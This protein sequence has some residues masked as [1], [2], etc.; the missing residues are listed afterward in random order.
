M[1]ED[2]FDIAGKVVALLSKGDPALADLLC[3]NVVYQNLGLELN[4][5]TQV[6]A[7]LLGK[8]SGRLYRDAAWGAPTAHGNAA[9]LA[10]QLPPESGFNDKLLLLH[11]R[12]DRVSAIQEQLRL[13]MAPL[14]ETPLSIGADLRRMI[15]SALETRSPMLL[16]YMDEGGQPVLSF[17]GSVQV[18]ADDCLAL[19]VRNPAGRLV[20]A[21]AANPKVALMY[22]NEDRRATYQLQGRAR[23]V[24][25]VNE[26]RRIHDGLPKVERD[27]DFAALGRA[28]IIELDRIEG[29][30]GVAEGRVVDPVNM[31]RIA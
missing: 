7:H 3:G 30:A 25:D 8:N 21:L 9:L 12:G 18:V 16:A 27:H 4:G 10:A 13:P 5:R 22:R 11:F 19:W 17:R 23:I 29:Y 26:Q 14:G 24:D 15:N 1:T 6:L 20:R 28:V 31:R 2:Q